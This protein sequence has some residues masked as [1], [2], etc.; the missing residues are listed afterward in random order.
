MTNLVIPDDDAVKRSPI[1]LST[2]TAATADWAE[3]VAAGTFVVVSE[4]LAIVRPLAS[5]SDN[6]VAL[7]SVNRKSLTV[8]IKSPTWELTIQTSDHLSTLDP[9][10]YLF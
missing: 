3:K 2:T 9:R 10:V 5:R 1:V 6:S 7:V 4:N 8:K